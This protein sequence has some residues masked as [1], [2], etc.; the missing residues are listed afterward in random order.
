MGGLMDAL[1][2][3]YLKIWLSSLV[4]DEEEGAKMLEMESRELSDNPNKYATGLPCCVPEMI[5]KHMHMPA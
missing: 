5:P 4:Q 3:Y 1:Q 2:Y